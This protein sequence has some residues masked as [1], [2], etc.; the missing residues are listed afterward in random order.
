MLGDDVSRLHM[1]LHAPLMAVA[2]ASLGVAAILA[3]LGMP[4]IVPLSI[5]VALIALLA[6]ERVVAGVR[7]A[8]KF[9]DRS[10]LLFVPVHMV[11]DLAWAAAIA[12]WLL[13]RMMGR[14][15]RPAHSM[16]PREAKTS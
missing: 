7:A 3:I 10:G 6:V 2:I 1:M 14:S 16:H 9:H 13:R 5:A 15:S 11:R 4:W 12:V 8:A